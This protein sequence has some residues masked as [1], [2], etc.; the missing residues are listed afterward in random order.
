[1]KQENRSIK[2]IGYDKF[3]V[4]FWT[5]HQLKIY[6]ECC[7]KNKTPTLS[8]DAAGGCCRKLKRSNQHLS[9]QIFLY[10]GI[11]NVKNQNFTALSMLSEQHDNIAISLWMKRWLKCNVSAP[12]VVISDQSLALMSAIVQSYTEYKTL[13]KYLNVC[14]LLLKNNNGEKPTCFIRNDVNHFVQ[15]IT[16]WQLL[17]SSKYPRTKQLFCRAM[18]LLIFVKHFDEAK[19]TFEAIFTIALSKYDGPC[20]DIDGGTLRKTACA[21]RKK[22]L[23]SLI[24]NNIDDLINNVKSHDLEMQTTEEIDPEPENNINVV[25]FKDWTRQIA[26]ASQIRVENDIGE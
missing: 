11:M 10:E 17:K 7:L 24:T 8:F 22:F 3:F 4:H 20:S 16:R 2:D 25:S 26:L 5:D 21:C 18:C 9:G 15:L 12:K 14:F 19:Q 6:K 1:M 23:Q 13:E